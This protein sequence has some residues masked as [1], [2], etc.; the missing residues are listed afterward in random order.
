MLNHEQLAF[1]KAM[2]RSE[3]S[4]VFLWELRRAV[5]AAK[6]KKASVGPWANAAS[7]SAL[8]RESGSGGDALTSRNIPQ[9]IVSKR[10]ADGLSS[11]DCP[12]SQPAAALRLNI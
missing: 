7:A 4:T 10:K 3:L 9:P 12:L 11:A 1:I 2:S 6:K 8:E 5:V